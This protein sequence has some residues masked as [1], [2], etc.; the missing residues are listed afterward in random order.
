M[1][2]KKVSVIILNWNGLKYLN[3][4]IK[5]VKD[6]T[7]PNV[8]IVLI[9]NNSSDSSF[10]IATSTF[11]IDKFVRNSENLGFARGMNIGIKEATGDYLMI[12]NMDVYLA[13]NAIEKAMANFV[14]I[15]NAG[16]VMGKE[17][18][19]NNGALI[20]NETRSSGPGFLKL[21]G[22]GFFDKNRINKATFSFGAMGSFPIFRREV[23]EQLF[24]I[25]GYYFDPKFET[26]W[27]D[28]DIFFRSHHLGWKFFYNPDIIGY[29]SVSGSVN[30]KTKL[31]DKDLIYQQ[32]IFRNRYYFI[33]K[34]YPAY[35]LCLHFPFL[36]LTELVLYPYYL[37]KNP[38]SI[39]AL[40]KAQ[41][42]F[43]KNLPLIKIER[44]KILDK[45]VLSVIELLAFFKKF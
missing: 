17:F 28:K 24:E 32:R 13:P 29:H 41:K 2:N 25:T 11:N 1:V 8:E 36:L 39:K 34:N 5:S 38:K 43:I 6:Q 31:I 18:S 10:E 4:C 3:K 20:N 37:Y 40:F 44:E 30:N 33:Y 22:Q 9:D 23:L 16:I 42:E 21:R 35:L 27:E 7:Y 26:G 19:W 45:S 14:D 15:S 12:L